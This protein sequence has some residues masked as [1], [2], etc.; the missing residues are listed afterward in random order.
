[1]SN[2]IFKESDLLTEAFRMAE[3]VSRTG[4]PKPAVAVAVNGECVLKASEAQPPRVLNSSLGA[5]ITD[6]RVKIKEF[7]ASFLEEG[8]EKKWGNTPMASHP[9]ELIFG[10][11]PS[12]AADIW[13]LGCTIFEILGESSLFQCFNQDWDN[14]IA[15]LVVAFGILPKHWWE[16][17]AKRSEYFLPDGSPKPDSIHNCMQN[18]RPLSEKLRFMG[19][20]YFPSFGEFEPEEMRALNELLRGMLAYLPQGRITA[21]DASNS[22]WMEHW[23]LK[24]MREECGKGK[25]K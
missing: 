18:F 11:E 20:G 25:K 19:R 17:W 12:Q 23:G 2:I 16:K 3:F 10:E 9:P 22:R 4:R 15:E 24:A 14:M 6:A 21:K 5:E 8:E 1:M 13:T 7:S